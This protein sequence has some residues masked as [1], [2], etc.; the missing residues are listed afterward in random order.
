MKNQLL[1][2][3]G[4]TVLSC[5]GGPPNFKT[6][7]AK[8]LKE[9]Y[10]GIFTENEKNENLFPI[11]GTGISTDTIVKSAKKFLVSLSEQELKQ[12]KY[13]IDDNEWRKWANVDNGVYNRQ[14]ISLKQMTET[15]KALAWA[16]L[17]TSL[18]AK[19]LQLTK[20][21]MKTD[22]TLKELTQ[23]LERF[24]EELYF[25]TIIGE[26]SNTEPWGWQIDGHHLVINYFVLGDQVV[27]SPV[28]MGAEPVIAPSGKYK[29]NAVFQ[30]EQ[31]FGLAFMQSLSKEQQ[32]KA[33]VSNSKTSNNNVAEAFQDNLTLKYQGIAGKDLDEKQQKQ[34]LSLIS[35]YVNNMREGHQQVKMSEVANHINNTWFSWVGGIKENDV[36][37]YRIHS[38]VI[39]IEFDHQGAISIRKGA[40]GRTPTRNHIHINVRTP[41]GNDYGK[42]LLRQH[43]EKHHQKK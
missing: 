40:N 41:N 2:L 14:G 39:L 21:I 32:Q 37:Y 4:F 38:P 35:Q 26:P 5:N 23:E 7:E 30:D 36:F 43:I 6:I 12:T 16:L 3:I 10:K 27:M 31:N 11:K 24:D 28:F 22:H 42:D 29:G 34:L 13:P 8:A 19:G 1:I 17:Q 15:Q 33:T 25:L 9:D 18:S 20:N